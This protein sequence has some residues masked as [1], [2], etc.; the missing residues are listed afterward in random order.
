MSAWLLYLPQPHV[1]QARAVPAAVER[2]MVMQATSTGVELQENGR[3]L[4]VLH[5]SSEPVALSVNTNGS[6]RARYVDED[7]GQMT[8]TNVYAE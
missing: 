2:G 1:E 6:V 3:A 5:R 7:T 8:I 4:T